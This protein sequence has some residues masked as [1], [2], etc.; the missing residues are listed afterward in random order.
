MGHKAA[1]CVDCHGLHGVLPNADPDAPTNPQHAA[2]I[3]RKCHPGNTKDFAFSYASH[4]RLNVERSVVSPLEK[5]CVNS[6]AGGI[7][8]GLLGMV[9]LG[10]RRAMP[11]GKNPACNRRLSTL[12]IGLCFFGILIGIT[13]LLSAGGMA[14]MHGPDWRWPAHA[15]AGLVAVS[16]LG[17]L[18][19]RLVMPPHLRKDP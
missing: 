13:V 14:L 10:V 15:A 6:L 12:V 3:C 4:F 17:L 11:R 7:L 19:N 5:L 2:G 8:F 18:V 1:T 9:V 16:L